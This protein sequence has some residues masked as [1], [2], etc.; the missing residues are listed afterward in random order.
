[1]FV[2]Q[3]ISVSVSLYFSLIIPQW[4]ALLDFCRRLNSQILLIRVSN[5]PRYHTVPDFGL[6]CVWNLVASAMVCGTR[7]IPKKRRSPRVRASPRTRGKARRRATGSRRPPP[8]WSAR[9]EVP[10]RPWDPSTSGRPSIQLTS[11]FTTRSSRPTSG[12]RAPAETP[13]DLSSL[14]HAPREVK[15]IATPYWS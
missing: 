1:M 2:L 6:T 3:C 14:L 12:A 11:R 4:S 9:G 5:T 13:T 8:R 15:F 10:F 7:T